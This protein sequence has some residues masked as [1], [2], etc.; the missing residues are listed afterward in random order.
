MHK[1]SLAGAPDCIAIS[2][3]NELA[4][5]NHFQ[6]LFPL[7]NDGEGITVPMYLFKAVQAGHA[8]VWRAVSGIWGVL[9]RTYQELAAFRSET[10]NKF[11][12]TNKLVKRLLNIVEGRETPAALDRVALALPAT[13]K[14]N[15][16]HSDADMEEES[17]EAKLLSRPPPH[18]VNKLGILQGL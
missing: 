13:E 8:R 3:E 9:D 14:S 15:Q 4:T 10:N 7:D 17:K 2:G 6:Q 11:D 1:E 18:L 12:E 16:A 5:Q